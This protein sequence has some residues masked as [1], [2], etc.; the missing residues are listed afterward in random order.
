MTNRVFI[1]S[2]IWVYLFSDDENHKAGIVEK[3]LADS[4][5]KYVFITSC[6]V[7]NEVSNVLKRH[8]FPEKKIRVVIQDI[9]NICLIQDLY[10]YQLS[11]PE[12]ASVYP[13]GKR[14]STKHCGG[15][16]N[17]LR[18]NRG[19]FFACIQVARKI[20]VLF[21]GQHHCRHGKNRQL[22]FV[23]ERRHAGWIGH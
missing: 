16:F 22:R 13:A 18:Y 5:S 2:N 1:D 6:Q 7:V 17:W 3:F 8:G 19:Y 21:L 23:D 11:F 15:F 9:T 14:T 10:P 12:C 4:V 20:F